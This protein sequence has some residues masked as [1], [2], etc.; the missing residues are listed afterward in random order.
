MFGAVPAPGLQPGQLRA[1][2]GG[3][4][5]GVDRFDVHA[6]RRPGRDR[7]AAGAASRVRPRAG[8]RSPRRWRPAGADLQLPGPDLQRL[9]G[10]RAGLHR[11]GAGHVGSVVVVGSVSSWPPSARPQGPARCIGLVLE[12]SVG[13][14]SRRRRRASPGR[15]AVSVGHHRGVAASVSSSA[16]PSGGAVV[17][18]RRQ[19][20]GP[21]AAAEVSG[22]ATVASTAVAWPAIQRGHR[23]SRPGPGARPPH[24]AGAPAGTRPPAGPRGPADSRWPS[25]RVDGARPP[26]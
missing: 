23:R 7:S 10:E 1:Q 19:R 24:R 13:R 2:P 20:P 14:H 16:R 22:V 9:R 17:M 8:S 11:G 25:D 18:T 26:R 12:S 5:G 4:G 21:W 6:R 3:G 15:P